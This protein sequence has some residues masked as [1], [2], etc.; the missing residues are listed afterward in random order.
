MFELYF[1]IFINIYTH[2]KIV[3]DDIYFSDEEKTKYILMIWFL[4]IIG[5]LISVYRLNI[6]KLFYLG[7]IIVH[8]LLR[9]IYYC[10]I[11]S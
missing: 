3:R 11:F 4:P 2:I 6:N 10:M 8:G 5:V 1:I 7:V 9:Y